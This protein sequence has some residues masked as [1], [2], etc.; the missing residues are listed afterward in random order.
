MKKTQNKSNRKS[1]NQK[2]K[3][4]TENVVEPHIETAQQINKEEVV[5]ENKD[6][7]KS[8]KEEKAEKAEKKSL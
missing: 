6:K 2:L 5:S 4:A 7:R 1:K 3:S 8:K